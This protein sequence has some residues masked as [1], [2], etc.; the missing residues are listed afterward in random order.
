MIFSGGNFDP[1]TCKQV[2]L[3][4]VLSL[5]D[6]TDQHER[7]NDNMCVK[8]QIT[9]LKNLNNFINIMFADIFNLTH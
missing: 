8:P 9:I 6:G 7:N 4:Y 2:Q 3:A 5:M 1:F